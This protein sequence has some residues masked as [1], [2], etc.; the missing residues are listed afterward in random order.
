MLALLLSMGTAFSQTHKPLTVKVDGVNQQQE[1]NIR[2]F[3][4]IQQ[5][6][7]K[8]VT[9]RVRLRYL[10]NKAETEISKALQPFG[11]YRPLTKSTLTETE[12]GWL[13]RYQVDPGPLLPI[14][15]VDIQLQGDAL[16]DEAFTWLIAE[17]TLRPG[18]PLVH[19][20][21]ES[22]KRQLRSLAAERGYYRAVFS[23]Q[24]VEVDLSLYE[25]F[26]SLHFDSGPRFSVGELRFTPG[27]LDNDFLDR[28]VD[29]NVGDPILSSALIDLQTSLID[30]DYFQQVE[31][32]PQWDQSS[33]T[34]VPIA[35]NLE[36]H[37][38]T[39]YLT[40]LGYGTDTG[41]RAKLGMTQ[42]WVNSKGHKLNTQLLTSQIRNSLNSQ[43]S[44]P[45]ERPKEDSY[46]VRVSFSDENSDS[47]DAQSYALGISWQTQ[48]QRWEQLLALDWT[49]ETY[50]FGDVT[51]TSEFLIPKL[52]LTRVNTPDRLS[53]SRGN[54]FKLQ[55]RGGSDALLSDTNFVQLLI[56]S[57]LVHSLTPD[58]RLLGRIDGGLTMVDNFDR[59]PATL[60]FYAG[61]DNSVRGYKYQS[62]GLKDDDGVVI[63][64]RHLLV[65]SAEV[66]YRI[67]KN[68]GLAAFVDSG[69]AFDNTHLS[70]HTGIGVGVRW[71]TPI[72]P[73]RFD[74]GFPQTG[75]ETGFRLHFSLGP[76]L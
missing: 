10:H 38:R 56:G 30:T 5:L 27:P 68:W 29:F 28:Y 22:F 36:P 39:K 6:H 31:V 2:G 13:A 19:A 48:K 55:L 75:D 49:V 71:F 8:S 57:K 14:G 69:N 32:S 37:K 34:A 43:Y 42:R 46:A 26:I 35:I 41:A 20:D 44:I 64:G 58:L 65:M 40:G 15:G 76:D 72:G 11:F 47:I 23:K 61:G 17:S 25:A 59:L 1:Q 53:V 9:S 7:T 18:A 63:G 33:D 24:G 3:L 16:Q 67:R 4:S 74:L 21:Y 60:R 51:Q 12:D 66:D 70:L 50:T 54:R 52:N 45:G 62:L 73:V